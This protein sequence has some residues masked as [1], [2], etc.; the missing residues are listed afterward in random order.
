M[1]DKSSGQTF[2]KLGQSEKTPFLV[3]VFLA[4]AG[5]FFSFVLF[6]YVPPASL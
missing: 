2:P 4:K 3:R 6:F 5:G 1:S